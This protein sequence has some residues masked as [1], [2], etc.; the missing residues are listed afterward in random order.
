MKNKL[1]SIKVEKHFSH[2]L[3]NHLSSKKTRKLN[4]NSFCILDCTCMLKTNPLNLLSEF[5][6]PIFKKKIICNNFLKFVNGKNVLL[7]F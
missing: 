2:I 5:E 1:I 4:F 6:L 3:A 7:T